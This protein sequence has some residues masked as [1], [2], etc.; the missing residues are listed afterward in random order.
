VRERFFSL[1]PDLLATAGEDGYFHDLNPAWT[2]VLGWSLAELRA[3]PWIDF[4]H[5]DDAAASR[6][7]RGTWQS[8]EPIHFENRYRHRDGSYRWLA[9]SATRMIDGVSYLI[10]RDVTEDKRVEAALQTH[11]EALRLE[12]EVTAALARVGRE[13]LATG[14]VPELPDRLTHST[15]AA[16]GCDACHLFLWDAAGASYRAVSAAGDRPEQWELLRATPFPLSVI[17]PLQAPLE[18]GETTHVLASQV[19]A[20]LRE[21]AMAPFGVKAIAVVALRRGDQII[22]VLS[23]LNRTRETPFTPQQLRIMEGV[24]QLGSFALESARLFEDLDRANRFRSEFVATMSHELRTPMSV[25]LGYQE[26]LLDGAFGPLTPAQIDT[27]RRANRSAAE[28]LGLVNATLDLSRLET[29]QVPLAVEDLSVARLLDDV[30]AE[31]AVPQEKTAL[32][33]LWQRPADELTIR[34]DP[35]KARMVLKN[36]VGNAIKFTPSGQVTVAALARDGGVELAV[37]DTGIGIAP[38]AQEYIFEA[39]RQVDGS[40]TRG[41]GGAGLGL[42]IV[43]R[44]LDA[45]GGRI[46]VESAL[47]QGATFRVWLPPRPQHD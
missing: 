19:P 14:A 16:V 10:A 30:A 4:V 1:S 20:T 45:L 7:L 6:A 9:W 39:F 11:S 28:L 46:S 24:A 27:L 23:C 18:R 2:R 25:I 29:R 5:P 22:G 33:V 43:R 21:V 15:Q 32:R 41:Y 12:G 31:I 36:L 3:R 40:I 38:E 35:L 42:H 26:L 47:G 44:L 37:S 34:T 8:A 17:G 13:L